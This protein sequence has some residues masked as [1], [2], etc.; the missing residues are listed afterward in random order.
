V[1]S[2]EAQEAFEKLKAALKQAPLLASPD[3]SKPFQ[4]ATDAS[5]D[6]FGAVLQQQGNPIA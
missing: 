6:G 4:L 3:F 2:A 5:K 1:L